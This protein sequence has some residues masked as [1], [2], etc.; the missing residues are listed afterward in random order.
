MKVFC[1]NGERC[2][3][4][5]LGESQAMKQWNFVEQ[6]PIEMVEIIR[7]EKC[8]RRRQ[9]WPQQLERIQWVRK[10]ENVGSTEIAMLE[11]A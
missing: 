9:G 8:A 5:S 4:G 10:K 11:Q 7:A 2:H 3:T 6:N 1:R